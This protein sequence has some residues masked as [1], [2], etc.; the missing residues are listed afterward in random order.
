M[1]YS[2]LIMRNYVKHIYL[3]PIWIILKSRIYHMHIGSDARY[4]YKIKFFLL[5]N[6][7]H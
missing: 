7:L 3:N 4:L 1:C 2:D 5:W 6:G